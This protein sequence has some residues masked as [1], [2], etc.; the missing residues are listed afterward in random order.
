MRIIATYPH[1]TAFRYDLEYTGLDPG[2]YN[3]VDYLRPKNAAA[4]AELPAIPIEITSVL[5]AGQIEP[6][7][8]ERSDLPSIGG[9]RNLM[10]ALGLLWLAGLVALV[11]KRKHR[12]DAEDELAREA[13]LAE[14]LRPI[15]ESALAG[16]LREGEQ[17]ELERLLLN[18]WRRRL[19]LEGVRP[20]QAVAQLR[21]HEEAG[22]LLRQLEAWLHRPDPPEQVD[23]AG[24]LEPY[25]HL[26]V[27]E[28][29]LDESVSPPRRAAVNGSHM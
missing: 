4:A 14:R 29:A 22:R 20:A 10:I 26:P 5:P 21:E 2:T 11:W 17:A 3:L 18:Y 24:L 15:V 7:T 25:R 13:S 27:D 28:F 8:L 23:L 1:G 16:K 6:R 12:S 19:G 9:Y